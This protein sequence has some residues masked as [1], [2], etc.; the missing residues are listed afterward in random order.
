MSFGLV[1]T[2]SVCSS[3]L[4]GTTGAVNC[5]F[6]G[7]SVHCVHMGVQ[8]VFTEPMDWSLR[9]LLVEGNREVKK[10]HMICGRP[11]T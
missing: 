11:G 2:H 9:V 3:I 1:Q 4:V 8:A 7:E 5:W 6:Y 10:Q